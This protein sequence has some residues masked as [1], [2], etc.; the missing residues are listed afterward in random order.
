MI[1]ERAISELQDRPE[2][3]GLLALDNLAAKFLRDPRGFSA[4]QRREMIASCQQGY[5]AFWERPDLGSP[6]DQAAG[7]DLVG[8]GARYAT[9]E[10]LGAEPRIDDLLK[11]KN[12]G[13][14]WRYVN[15]L[16]V[17]RVMEAVAA[18]RT[19][20]PDG[21]SFVETLVIHSPRGLLS[22]PNDEVPPYE[23][24]HRLTQT[25][26]FVSTEADVVRFRANPPQDLLRNQTEYQLSDEVA[27]K[28]AETLAIT[29]GFETDRLLQ[30]RILEILEKGQDNQNQHDNRSIMIVGAQA[31]RQ[32]A[33]FILNNYSEY[34]NRESLISPALLYVPQIDRLVYELLKHE[35]AFGEAQTRQLP[36]EHL[37]VMRKENKAMKAWVQEVP[38]P[39]A[40]QANNWRQEYADFIS[41]YPQF[42]IR[43]KPRKKH[44]RLRRAA[45]ITTAAAALAT[46]T[47]GI[48]D[49][50]Q[51][52]LE[53]QNDTPSADIIPSTTSTST[54]LAPEWNFMPGIDDPARKPQ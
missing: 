49:G 22:E 31:R 42:D 43:K 9:F 23:P 19:P 4:D 15:D 48:I 1:P 47:L 12:A 36:P 20:R 39:T 10:V 13:N 32:F 52:V 44:P 38:P 17:G 41:V 3:S 8:M 29:D 30:G 54:P 14:R 53:E 37:A 5:R 24:L 28:Y 46:A 45:A 18:D 50:V 7:L 2:M 51:A 25:G 35:A 40:A 16:E 11:R 21:T 33:D 6:A 26:Q 27:F 34:A